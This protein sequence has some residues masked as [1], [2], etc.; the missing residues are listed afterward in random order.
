MPLPPPPDRPYDD[1]GR[2]LEGRYGAAIRHPDL[3]GPGR[4]GKYRLK[5]WHYTS[6]LTER[7]FV[8]FGL[9]QLG[10]VCNAF[11]Y[12]VELPVGG[13]PLKMR[14]GEALRPLG[15]GLQFAPSSVDGTTRYQA[16]G[17]RI[18]VA[19]DG[20]GWHCTLDVALQDTRL[21]ADFQFQPAEAL[22]L[23][24]QLPSGNPA[25][26]HK[27]AGLPAT[28]TLRLGEEELPATGLATLDWTRSVAQRRTTWKWASMATLLPDGRRLGLNLSTEVYG[29][30]E[31]ALW[32][33][34]EVVPL[35]AV[36]F[37]LPS[38]P[39]R[40]RWRIQSV[41]DD[42]VELFFTPLCVRSQHVDLGL[43]ISDFTQPFGRFEGTLRPHGLAPLA[44]HEACGVVESHLSVW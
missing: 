36:R 30:A 21:K 2:L 7:L 37:E 8:A 1:A 11:W 31:N 14:Q 27:E 26:T 29:D 13:R 12:A 17:N 42:E 18:E 22:A 23:L 43:I 3:R 28:G 10:Y 35:G 9:V 40:E 19:W 4:M 6:L 16:D 34:G 32:L 15:R 25:Y 24:Y 20:R 5:E 38:D 41:A 44:L 33:D 39:A